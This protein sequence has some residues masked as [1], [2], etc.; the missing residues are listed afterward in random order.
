MIAIDRKKSLLKSDSLLNRFAAEYY[1]VLIYQDKN[2]L[3]IDFSERQVEKRKGT[4]IRG[5]VMLYATIE[6]LPKSNNHAALE[7]VNIAS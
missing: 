3:L 2:K 7:R 1:E 4:S 5:G 6:Y